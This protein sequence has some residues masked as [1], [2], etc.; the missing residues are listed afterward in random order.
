MSEKPSKSYK[1]TIILPKTDFAMKADLARREPEQLARWEAAD[2]YGQIRAARKGAP[3]FILHD[4]PPYA[5]GDLHVGTGLNKV[6]KDLVVRYKTM[7]GFDSP[8]RPGWDCHGLPIEH[9]VAKELGPKARQ[10][11]TSDIRKKCL[12]YA[13]KYF[14]RNREDFKRQLIFGDWAN[15]YLTVNHDYEAGVL[16][17]FAEMVAGGYVYRSLR[18]IHW[19]M[20]DRTALAEAEL[21]YDDITS[22]SVYVRFPLTEESVSRAALAFGV[23]SPGP[24]DLVIWTTTPWTLPANLGIAVHHAYDYVLFDAITADAKNVRGI[25]AEGLLD[26]VSKACKLEGVKIVGKC[27]GRKL[28]GLKYRHVF[29]DRTSPVVLANY[30]TLEDG[31]GCVHTAPGHGREDFITGQSYGLEPLSPVDPSGRF[32]DAGGPFVGQHVLR[33][34]P[35]RH[36]AARGEGGPAG[37]H[38]DQ[39]QLPALLALPR[40]GHLPGHRAVVR[41]RRAR[42]PAQSADRGSRSRALDPRLGQGPHPGHGEHQA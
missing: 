11:S 23:T 27:K 19:C 29:M 42:Q 1:D 5:T 7:R 33:C 25:V 28:E 2:I 38:A 18:P 21:E 9:K 24:I 4:G 8:Y 30:V 34:G 39:A 26:A 17:L 35:Q 41:Q 37:L 15:P 16:D 6:L 31:T 40:A 10:M 36:Q 32:T 3:K 14:N 12:D 20:T 13:M 22:P